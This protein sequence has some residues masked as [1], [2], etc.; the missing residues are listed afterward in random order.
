MI[1]MF[2][3]WSHCSNLH[4]C[5]SIVFKSGPLLFFGSPIPHPTVRLSSL[6]L[7]SQPF[8]SLHLFPSPFADYFST[9]MTLHDLPNST[10]LPSTCLLPVIHTYHGP[11]CYRAPSVG[12][13]LSHSITQL[14]CP[15]S[16]AIIKKLSLTLSL[17]NR[18]LS[19]RS[20]T[21]HSLMAFISLVITH[22]T[23]RLSD[24]S[25][26]PFPAQTSKLSQSGGHGCFLLFMLSPQTT[27][28]GLIRHL[29]ESH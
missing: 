18:S 2:Y 3:V 12:K 8:V 16:I 19:V 9:L 25:L 22:L 6:I 29:V 11:F 5:F 10:L 28:L 20:H 13:N 21:F 14:M 4:P 27:G 26:P 1:L 17:L 15:V 23:S 24:L 7:T